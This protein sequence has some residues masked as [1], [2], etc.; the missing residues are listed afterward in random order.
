MVWVSIGKGMDEIRREEGFS[1]LSLV[2][3]KKGENE[4]KVMIQRMRVGKKGKYGIVTDAHD[5]ASMD[6]IK[7]SNNPPP[8]PNLG[9]LIF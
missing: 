4:G 8:S 9:K 5:S 2:Q 3:E 1:V 7:I 6:Q